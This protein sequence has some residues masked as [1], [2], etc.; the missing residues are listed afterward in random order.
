MD[1]PIEFLRRCHWSNSS[2][3]RSTYLIDVNDG[4]IDLGPGKINCFEYLKYQ[5]NKYY[6]NLNKKGYENR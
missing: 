4:K 3:F 2:S 5:C 1:N 6:R